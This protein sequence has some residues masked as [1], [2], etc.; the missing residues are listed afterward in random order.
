MDK[1]NFRIEGLTVAVDHMDKMVGFYSG[2]FNVEFQKKE[3]YGSTL[4]SGEWCGFQLL[5]CPAQ[6]AGIDVNRNRQQFDIVVNKLEELVQA[7][8]DSGGKIL[9]EITVQEGFRT[10]AVFDPDGNSIV[11]KEYTK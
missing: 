2:V 8:L 3:L 11:L 4:F 6:L 5:F 7:A 10:A 1:S 9:Q